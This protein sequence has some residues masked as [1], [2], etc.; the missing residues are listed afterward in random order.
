VLTGNAFDKAYMEAMEKAHHEDLAAFQHEA[1][2]AG[3][4]HLKKV[5]AEG[6]KVIA[7]HTEMADKLAQKL[8]VQVA[9]K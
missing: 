3:D 2:S 4:P 8:G 1:S 6:E 7:M 5:V 9:A